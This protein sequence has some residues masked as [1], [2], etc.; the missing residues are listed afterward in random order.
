MSEHKPQ[1][2]TT[3]ALMQALADGQA[4]RRIASAAGAPSMESVPRTRVADAKANQDGLPAEQA[5][6]TVAPEHPSPPA[7]SGDGQPRELASRPAFSLMP[8][9]LQGDG[10]ARMQANH[11]RDVDRFS[12]A[13]AGQ[14]PAQSSTEKPA[15]GSGTS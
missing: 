3:E 13:H 1:P 10:A 8:N 5:R 14:S 15:E 12:P 11:G 6:R 7:I 2:M 9:G 4:A